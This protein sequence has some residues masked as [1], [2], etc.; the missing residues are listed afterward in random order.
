MGDQEFRDAVKLYLERYS[1]NYAE[2]SNFLRC[3]YYVTG[4]SYGWFFEEWVLHGGEPNYKVTY[5]VQDDTLGKR[6]TRFQVWQ[7]HETNDL[8]GLFKMPVL[9]E[10]HYKDGSSDRSTAWIENKYS[11]VVIPDPG[12]RS[13]EYTL[14]D[15]GRQVVKKVTFEKS[16]EELSA[17][18]M[19][20]ENMIDRYDALV[21]L[22]QTPVPDKRKLLIKCYSKEKF[23]LIKSEILE[24]LS[25]DNTPESVELFREALNDPDATVR[26][27]VLLNVNPAPWILAADFEK[28]LNDYSY[29]NIELA[30]DNLSSS[31]PQ[32]V[33]Q[34]LEMTKNMTG[35]R[36]MNIRMKW[37]QVAI[38]SGK[39]EYLQ[40]LIS[41]SGPKYEF[42]TRMNSLNLLKKIR[43]MDETTIENARSAGK[44][45]NN[46]LSTV[47]K[48]YLVY[49]GYSLN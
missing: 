38:G 10:V 13:I 35:W 4:K 26:K 23:Y 25:K 44:H 14:F 32:N 20:A 47:G 34:Y 33:D 24:Q 43:Y 7:T 39:K 2:T 29:L 19:K 5:A 21:A 8:V 15:P 9:F 37:L 1:F 22:K 11:E 46:K 45:W 18:A 6:S 28:C 41:Y 16:F 17:Q 40:E 31:F 3:T 49:F 27:S 36:G 48:E 30:L 42:E 12:K